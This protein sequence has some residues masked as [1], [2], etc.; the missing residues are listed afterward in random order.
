MQS[1]LLFPEKKPD[2]RMDDPRLGTGPLQPLGTNI[3]HQDRGDG[4]RVH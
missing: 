1:P 4:G 3:E 2:C